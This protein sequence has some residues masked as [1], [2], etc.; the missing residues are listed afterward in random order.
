M[1]TRAI[2]RAKFEI[3]S[4]SFAFFEAIDI[5]CVIPDE[6]TVVSERAD[7]LVGGGGRLDIVI[8]PATKIGN[9]HVKYGS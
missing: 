5:L 8:N 3:R 1:K 9:E 2:T 4:E 6:A 7:K